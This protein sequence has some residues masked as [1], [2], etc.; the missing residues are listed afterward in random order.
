MLVWLNMI[1]VNIPVKES[2]L[3]ILLSVI[4]YE[5]KDKCNRN[6]SLKKNVLYNLEHPA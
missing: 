6:V 4:R 1:C 5:G 2:K 3:L